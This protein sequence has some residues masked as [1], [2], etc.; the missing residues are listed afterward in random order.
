MGPYPVMVT[1]PGDP[2]PSQAL[3][4][5]SRGDQRHHHRPRACSFISSHPAGA[6]SPSGPSNAGLGDPVVFR[7]QDSVQVWTVSQG[8]QVMIEAV[9]GGGQGGSA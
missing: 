5:T 9:G 4:G 7:Q 2:A 3:V 1:R 8:E 6:A